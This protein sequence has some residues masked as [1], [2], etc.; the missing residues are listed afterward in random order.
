M[1]WLTYGHAPVLALVYVHLFAHLFSHLSPQSISQ[2]LNC[3]VD[4]RATQL[5]DG[6]IFTHTSD[7]MQKLSAYI[8]FCLG[9]ILGNLCF[10]VRCQQLS[11]TASMWTNKKTLMMF[12]F[13]TEQQPITRKQYWQAFVRSLIWSRTV[14]AKV[15]VYFWQ[16]ERNLIWTNL[17]QILM[18]CVF[19]SSGLSSNRSR[20]L[21]S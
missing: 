10:C 7:I 4:T 19:C 12:S 13:G 21:F 20:F 6:H 5:T 1:P 17:D 3:A 16:T 2:L 11:W 14:I 18:R 15:P 8:C 9:H